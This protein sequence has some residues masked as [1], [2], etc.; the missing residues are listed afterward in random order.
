MRDFLLSADEFGQ[1]VA[2]FS[3]EGFNLG[4]GVRRLPILIGGNRLGDV[5]LH[6]LQLAERQCLEPKS[7]IDAVRVLNVPVSIACRGGGPQLPPGK[8]K[9]GDTG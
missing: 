2:E 5:L 8:V 7:A 6:F 9:V 4:A 1:G 3:G